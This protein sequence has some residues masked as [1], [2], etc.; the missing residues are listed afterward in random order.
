[1]SHYRKM[2]VFLLDSHVPFD[3]LPLR[4]NWQAGWVVIVLCKENY[5]KEI[6]IQQERKNETHRFQH[7]MNWFASDGENLH[8]KVK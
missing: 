3:S 8:V 2:V 6:F 7:N 4:K 1:M 5:Y